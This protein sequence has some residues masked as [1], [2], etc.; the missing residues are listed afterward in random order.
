MK[1][2]A[3]GLVIVGLLAGVLLVPRPAAA[4]GGGHFVGGL[5]VGTATGLILGGVFAPRVVYAPPPVYVAPPPAYY[6]Y[7]PAPGYAP[8]AVWVPGQWVW[9][10][11]AWVW[12]PGYWR[13]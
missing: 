8:G 12:Q 6:Y 2:L 4:W 13:Y 1:R 11:Y 3:A 9:S 7:P 5:A 10:G